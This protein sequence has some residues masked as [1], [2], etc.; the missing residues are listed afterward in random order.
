MKQVG[1]IEKVTQNRVVNLFKD[2]LGYEYLGDWE[3]KEDNSN[4][5]EDILRK[6]LLKNGYNEELIARTITKLLAT[7]Y[8]FSQDLYNNNKTMYSFLRY[9]VQVPTGIGENNETVRLIDWI[10]PANNHFALA[11]IVLYVNGRESTLGRQ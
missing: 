4:I 9:G 7:V 8:N 11:D 10:N 5:E 3:Y 6:Y 2:R 1:D